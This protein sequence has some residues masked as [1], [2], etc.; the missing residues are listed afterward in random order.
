ME[1][2]ITLC[3]MVIKSGG[4]N[5]AMPADATRYKY[6]EVYN[7]HLNASSRTLALFFFESNISEIF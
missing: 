6:L 2:E 3:N 1:E 4:K 5:G 7:Y